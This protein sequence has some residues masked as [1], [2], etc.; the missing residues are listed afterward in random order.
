MKETFLSSEGTLGR[1]PF[2]VRLI[3]IIALN[4]GVN[5]G[6]QHFFSHWHHGHYIAL[7]Y[8]VGIVFALLSSFILLMQ[9][10]KR[11]RDMEKGAY[12]SMLLLVPGVNILFVLYATISPSRS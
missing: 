8:F 6:A 12:L 7:G 4:I 3:V 10:L 11:L 2:L 5:Y 9:V 1:I